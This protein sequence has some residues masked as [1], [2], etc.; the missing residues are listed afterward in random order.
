M[1]IN[2]GSWASNIAAGWH[3]CLD[4][5]GQIINGEA[6]VWDDNS[7]EL[8]EIYKKMKFNQNY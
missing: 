6:I 7:A 1:F 5:R 4:V 2:D 3:R 8:Q